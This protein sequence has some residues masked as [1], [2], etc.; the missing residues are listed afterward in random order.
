MV[1]W[2]RW[3]CPPGK[4]FEIPVGSRPSTLSLGQVGSLFALWVISRHYLHLW[5][6]DNILTVWVLDFF[7]HIWYDMPTLPVTHNTLR[8]LTWQHILTGH[9]TLLRRWNNVN[10]VVSTPL[11]TRSDT[12]HYSKTKWKW[13][14]T[15][16]LL[17][18]YKY[19][20]SQFQTE[21]NNEII[22]PVIIIIIIIIKSLFKE[23]KPNEHLP[24][25]LGALKHSKIQNT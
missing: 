19:S 25:F 5:T 22:I 8:L 13:Y 17:G 24:I 3:I 10:D 7:W 11:F 23:G 1:R 4:G 12:A 15:L 21:R 14:I 9:T 16:F 20:L 2:I 18:S 6:S